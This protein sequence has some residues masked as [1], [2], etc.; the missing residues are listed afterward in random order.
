M[1]RLLLLIFLFI[2]GCTAVENISQNSPEEPVFEPVVEKKEETDIQKLLRLH[3]IQR[4]MKG[5]VGFTLDQGLCDYAQ[6][7][8]EWMAKHHSMTH[9]DISVLVH[10]YGFV[11]EN[12][13]WNQQSPEEV[14]TA[15]MNSEGHRINI[16]NR[17]YTKIGFGI[18]YKNGEIWWCT[19]FGS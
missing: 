18:V 15:W 2:I 16:M 3:N 9:S 13:A 8:A 11:A 14:V 17:N 19:N 6:K 12:I 4:E 10:R 1:Q 5:R 7:H